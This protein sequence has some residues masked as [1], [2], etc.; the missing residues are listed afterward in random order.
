MLRLSVLSREHGSSPCLLLF[1]SI[2]LVFT[3]V[4]RLAS[5]LS[6]ALFFASAFRFVCRVSFSLPPRSFR[7]EQFR[8][9]MW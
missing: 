4:L 5:A 3:F 8:V 6:Y 9:F 7:F 2:V 1:H